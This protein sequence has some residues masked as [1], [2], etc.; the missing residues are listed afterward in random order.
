MPKAT[1]GSKAPEGCRFPIRNL[2]VLLAVL[3]LAGPGCAILGR[4]QYDQ[5]ISPEAVAKVEKGMTKAQVTELLGSPQEII[6]SNKM[7]D[8]LR[9]YAYIFEFKVQYATAIFFLVVNFGNM[10]E[11]RDRAIVFFGDDEKVSHVS[12]S[13]CAKQAGYGF[14]FGR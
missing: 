14:P 8:P 1:P 13:L 5:P 7:H 2:L 3:A 10:D 11:K 9:E 12:K 4:R 6:F